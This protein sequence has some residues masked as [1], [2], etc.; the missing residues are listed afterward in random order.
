MGMISLIQRC[1]CPEPVPTETATYDCNT[2]CEEMD[3]ACMSTT[4]LVTTEECPTEPTS[5]EG[6][7]DDEAGGDEETTVTDLETFPTIVSGKTTN[8]SVRTLVPL[9]RDADTCA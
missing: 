9:A 3:I 4:Y 2:P 1:G 5:A 6:D 8:F 7:G